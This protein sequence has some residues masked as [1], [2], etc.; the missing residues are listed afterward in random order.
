LGNT[1]ASL[2]AVDWERKAE[3]LFIALS[4]VFLSCCTKSVKLDHFEDERVGNIDSYIPVDA[5]CFPKG[6]AE[7]E[8]GALGVAAMMGVKNKETI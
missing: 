2:S 3:R 1:T 5:K 4:R 7:D 6:I 8:D